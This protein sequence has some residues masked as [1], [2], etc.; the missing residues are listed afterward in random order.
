MK[1]RISV[2]ILIGLLVSTGAR[3][4]TV[5]GTVSRSSSAGIDLNVLGQDG[6]YYPNTLPVRVENDTRFGGVRSAAELSQG[7]MVRAGRDEAGQQGHRCHE[8]ELGESQR[9]RV[10]NRTWSSG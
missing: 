4:D 7:D 3:A 5:W 2:V 9:S 10:R 1:R 8:W 6:R